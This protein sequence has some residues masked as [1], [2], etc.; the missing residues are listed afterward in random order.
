MVD[1]VLLN[2][3]EVIISSKIKWFNGFKEISNYGSILAENCV[4][5]YRMSDEGGGRWI[6]EK[7]GQTGGGSE[8]AY[9]R[10]MSFVNGP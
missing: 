1:I 7:A 3:H 8:N 2:N 6:S 9:F 10:R 4:K 5:N